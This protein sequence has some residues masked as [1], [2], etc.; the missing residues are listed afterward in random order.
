[1]KPEPLKSQ[2]PN[3]P[4]LS[5]AT[6]CIVSA[7][8][9][10]ISNIGLRRLSQLNCD[11]MWVVFNKELFTVIAIGLWLG[12]ET[13]HG[14]KTLPGGRALLWLIVVGLLVELVGNLA[15]Q[16]AMGVVGLAVSIPASFGTS[17]TGGAILATAFLGERVSL[18]S[19][20]AMAALW[21]ALGFLGLAAEGADTNHPGSSS[22]AVLL[23]GVGAA[24]L[25]GVIFSILGVMTCHFVRQD[26]SPMIIVFWITLMAVVTMGPLSIARLGTRCV[27]DTSWDAYAW[28]A[29]TGLFNLIGFIA[30]GKGYARTT[31]VHANVL[32]AGQVA[33]AAVAG[34][35]LFR[36]SPNAWL[37]LGVC[38]T[39]V[40]IL[41]AGNAP[42]N[43][44]PA[45][46]K[47]MADPYI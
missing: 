38:L 15:L 24:C 10:S 34:I 18:R 30:L 20:A 14:R 1:V 25:A 44:Q 27:F 21:I 29:A 42:R 13:C 16:W 32:N 7:I 36:E 6:Y 47:Q 4:G 3:R 5:G 35:F 22:A 12:W 23:L 33:M 46:D 11:P 37:I 9:Y 8:A 28:M 41:G 31:L 19:M 2:L 39:I 17:M 45:F 26:V 40:G 43:K